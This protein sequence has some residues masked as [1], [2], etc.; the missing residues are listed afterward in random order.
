[1]G[2]WRNQFE[3][4]TESLPRLQRLRPESISIL[5]DFGIGANASHPEI[6]LSGAVRNVGRDGQEFAE[7]EVGSSM[8]GD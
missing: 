7:Q 5:A 6:S 2:F 3:P 4:S 8:R 1:M